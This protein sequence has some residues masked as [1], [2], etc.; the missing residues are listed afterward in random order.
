MV[1]AQ[2]P[3]HNKNV[4]T[5]LIMYRNILLFPTKNSVEAFKL[6]EIWKQYSI[7]NLVISVT[8]EGIVPLRL[9]EERSLEKSEK[10]NDY[11]L[12]R[13]WENRAINNPCTYGCI[14]PCLDKQLN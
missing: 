9:L 2:V 3:A 13:P 14:N 6:K 4:I 11:N 8:L 10:E 5:L 7:C 1:V 12:C